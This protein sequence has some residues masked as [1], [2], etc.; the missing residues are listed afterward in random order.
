MALFSLT[1]AA[2]AHVA[3]ATN[4]IFLFMSVQ[5]LK[6]ILTIEQKFKS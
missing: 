4:I 2:H 6:F 5:D 3:H 1:R